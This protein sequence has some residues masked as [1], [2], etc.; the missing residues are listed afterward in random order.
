MTPFKHAADKPTP[1]TWATAG[2][3]HY[4]SRNNVYSMVR[5]GLRKWVVYERGHPVHTA[6]SKRKAMAYDPATRR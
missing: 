5:E 3:G 6:A 1:I 2:P 4:V